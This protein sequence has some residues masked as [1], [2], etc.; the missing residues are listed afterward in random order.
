VNLYGR[1]VGADEHVPKRLRHDHLP[2]EKGYFNATALRDGEGPLFV[3][4]GACDALSLLAAGY[5]R[6][7]AIFGLDG[8]RW[9]WARTV[10]ELVLAFDADP[11]GWRQGHELAR[12]ARLRGKQVCWLPPEAYGGQKDVNAAWVAGTLVVGT[13]PVG[14]EQWSERAAILEMDGGLVRHD[15]ERQAL[16]LVRG[17]AGAS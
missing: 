12:Q 1:A 7:V 15:A 16:A 3:C 9:A 13:R 2:G 17:E 11:A 8:W 6:V 4:E 14:W 5:A 10:S